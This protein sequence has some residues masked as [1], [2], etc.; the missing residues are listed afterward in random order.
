MAL[1]E[2]KCEKKKSITLQNFT[3]F[4]VSYWTENEHDWSATFDKILGNVPRKLSM[5]LEMQTNDMEAIS[6]S[7]HSK[8]NVKSVFKKFWFRKITSC[9]FIWTKKFSR[10]R[11][12]LQPVANYCRQYSRE[13]SFCLW[14]HMPRHIRCSK[15]RDYIVSHRWISPIKE[16]LSVYCNCS[17]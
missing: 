17:E 15:H 9:H 3:I 14:L 12:S 2:I 10:G 6:V 8:Q 7:R 1:L 16:N 11:R 5:I 4:G 13:M